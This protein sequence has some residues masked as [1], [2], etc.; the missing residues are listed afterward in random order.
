MQLIM[1]SFRKVV[2]EEEI[3][4][5]I[6][7]A[8][9][10]TEK[11]LREFIVKKYAEKNIALS[12]QQLNEVMPDWLKVLA[13]KAAMLGTVG[14]LA[15][16][17]A[18]QA[19]VV[20]DIPVTA[21]DGTEATYTLTDAEVQSLSDAIDDIPDEAEDDLQPGESGIKKYAA[22]LEKV[23]ETPD[24]DVGYDDISD[25][26]LRQALE[27]WAQKA[28]DSKNTP[29]AGAEGGDD[30]GVE[31]WQSNLE[32]KAEA[33]NE[34]AIKRLQQMATKGDAAQ[35]AWAKGVLNSL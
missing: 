27:M 10:L 12:E 7:N 15:M 26:G 29:E 18:A 22:A 9:S 17:T 23:A 5:Y 13:G 4:A 33:G 31:K 2:I 25:G 32:S 1:E 35:Q 16:G 3:T 21:A 34:I 6:K 11:Q 8:D 19:G 24:A 30:A 28:Y 20:S 14:S